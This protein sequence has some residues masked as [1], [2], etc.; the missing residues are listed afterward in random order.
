M[1][2]PGRNRKN[3]DVRIVDIRERT[4]SIASP[5]ANAYID[6]SKMT[7]SIVAVVTDVVR[8]GA[9]VVGYGFN[10]N[11]RYGQGALM[12]ER[13]LR[14]SPRPIRRPARRRRSE[15]RPVP[16]LGRLMRNEKPG[17][18]GERSVAVGTL[19]MAIWDAVAKIEGSRSTACSRTASA[20]ARPTTRSGSMRPAATTIPARTS[21]SA[22][23]DARLSRSRLRVV[24]MKIGGAPLAEDLQ[25][26][27]AV[28]GVVG[29]GRTSRSTP[30][31]AST[32]TRALAYA[33]ALEPYGLFWYE[34]AG[35]P[36]DYALAGRAAPATA[37]RPR[38][39]KTC[40]RTRT[41]ATCCAT[42]AWTRPRLA[43]VRLRA[44]LRPRRISAHPRRAEAERLVE[45]QGRA[46]RRPPDV[47]QHRRRTAPRRQRILS[48]RV[49]AVRRL[50]RR[51]RGRA[52]M[53]AC[54]TCP[55]SASRPRAT[56]SPCSAK[57]STHDRPN[58]RPT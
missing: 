54:P 2:V 3:S 16:H 28:L 53:S 15:P 5:I 43:A 4:V 6:F 52:A 47:A 17:G 24:K 38:P 10:S 20:T 31:A 27:E 13:L 26:I 36:L 14:G 55:A 57:S 30:T 12:R 1:S 46:A 35:D 18:H 42:A 41:P 49:P 51:Q 44:L 29:E 25:R 50:R 40:S 7:C 8:D 45:R 58:D 11:G 34:E 22:G 37:A 23:R 39:A 32:S 19:D 21:R 48:R 33:E 56:S 9:P